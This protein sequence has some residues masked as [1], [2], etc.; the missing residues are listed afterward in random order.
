R[1]AQLAQ[2]D[3]TLVEAAE[4]RRPLLQRLL[5]KLPTARELAGPVSLATGVPLDAVAPGGAGY[6]ATPDD[7]RVLIRA[8]IHE[9]AK[10]GQVVIVAH[11]AS[12]ALG[13]MEGVLRVLVTASPASRA[14]R[15]AVAQGISTEEAATAIAKS[16][17]E[18]REYFEAFYSIKDELP[19]HYDLVI[20]TDVLMPK[21]AVEVIVAA[22]QSRA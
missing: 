7:L 13:G 5:D 19:T 11:A 18:R 4:H 3:P 8:A 16:D 15:L 10:V 17:R 12:M 20:N 21:Q 1:A 9:V 6:R 2:V 22:A 14:R